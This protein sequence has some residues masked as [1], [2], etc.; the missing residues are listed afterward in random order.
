MGPR[1]SGILLTA[2]VG[3]LAAGAFAVAA[4]AVTNLGHGDP[5]DCRAPRH[6]EGRT[7]AQVRQLLGA[8]SSSGPRHQHWIRGDDPAAIGPSL[9]ELQVAYSAARRVSAVACV[10]RPY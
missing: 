8:P 1:L 4:L 10:S 3:V 5:P 9:I 6:L 7:R 2:V